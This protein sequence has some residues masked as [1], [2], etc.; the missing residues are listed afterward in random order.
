MLLS[1]TR[2]MLAKLNQQM[3]AKALAMTKASSHD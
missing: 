3:K 2:A 1:A